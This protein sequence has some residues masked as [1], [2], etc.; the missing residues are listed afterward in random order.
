MAKLQAKYYNYPTTARITKIGNRP[1]NGHSYIGMRFIHE[2]AYL[3]LDMT[4]LTANRDS[5]PAIIKQDVKD[6]NPT[7]SWSSPN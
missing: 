6:G 4:G 3:I 1:F 7:W 2:N 5:M